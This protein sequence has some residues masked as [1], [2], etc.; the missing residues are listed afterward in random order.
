MSAGLARLGG[1]PYRTFICVE[2]G[3]CA[4]LVFLVRVQMLN[5][6]LALLAAAGAL[7]LNAPSAAAMPAA[8]SHGWVATW[9]ASPEPADPDPDEPLLK[10]NGQTVRERVRISVGGDKIRVRLSNQYGSAPLTIG[11]A[12]AA[13][14][15]D[16]ANVEPESLRSLTFGG[17][18]TVTIPPGGAVLSD[19]AAFIVA[20]GGEISLS[21]YFPGPVA[22][23]TLHGVAMK[24]AVV[25]PAG[26][27]VLAAH[28]EIQA[29]SE[30]SILATQVLT[31]AR[32]GERLIAAF[33][34][35]LT[36]GDGSTFDTDRRW[37]NDLARRLAEPGGDSTLAVV[38]EGV[39]GNRLLADGP[40]PSLGVSGLARFD[41]DVLSLPGLTHV[42]VLEGAN[43]IGFPGANRQGF[44]LG[45]AAKAP[46]V[47]DLIAGYKRLIAMAHA[48]GV[49]VIGATLT[50]FEGVNMPG[51]YSDEKNKAREAVNQWI[52]TSGAF[53]GVVDF[54]AVVRDPDHPSQLAARYAARDHL[55]PND[56][57]YQALADSID[58]ALFR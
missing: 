40:L 54:D 57:G 52:R 37:S 4:K 42:I 31:P 6:R 15:V 29:K 20:P 58:L 49:K 39:A 21:L 45:D 43:D 36:D 12:T 5:V 44:P 53:D 32:P 47:Q 9:A 35:S 26:N 10:L 38:N 17:R 50:P 24:H 2:Y 22:T 8:P 13:L 7:G 48:R 28:V 1:K 25:T 34:D 18:P 11:A 56:A 46:S 14:A 16:A 19:P 55:H 51:Y 33:G 30:S 27:G 41:H 3:L 23:P